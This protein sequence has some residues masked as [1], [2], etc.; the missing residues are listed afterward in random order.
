MGA[1]TRSHDQEVGLSKDVMG[2]A[3]HE[4]DDAIDQ[5]LLTGD[6]QIALDFGYSLIKTAQLRGVQLMRLLYTLEEKWDS[7]QTDDTVEDAV[8]KGMGVSQ[9]KFSDYTRVYR[10][11]LKDHSELVGKPIGGLLEIIAAARDGDFSDE[12]WA[13]LALAHDKAAMIAI[14]QN[15]RGLFGQGFTRVT[16]SWDRDGFVWAHKEDEEPEALGQLNHKPA[17]EH[18]KVAID[19]L[20]DPSKGVLKR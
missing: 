20:M 17:T 4:V 16:I 5:S 13:D 2:V 7:F 12:D 3:D 9:R 10:Y 8:F 18:G 19:R 6:P 14:R 15:A 11:I 1:L